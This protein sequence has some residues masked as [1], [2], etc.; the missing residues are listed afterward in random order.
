MKLIVLGKGKTGSL[1]AELAQERGHE[2]V[3]LDEHDNADASALNL[4]N[5]RK[6]GTE[7]AIDFTTPTAVL[8]NIRACAKAKVNMVVGTTGWYDEIS[9]IKK[10]VEDNGI[11]LVYGSNFSVGVNVFFDIVR[12]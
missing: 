8:D 9:T 4:D 7:V 10:L 1:V 12:A 6:L 3:A 5:L 11:G 2:V